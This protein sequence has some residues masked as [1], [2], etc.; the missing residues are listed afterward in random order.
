LAVKGCGTKKHFIYLTFVKSIS[1]DGVQI[2]MIVSGA[3]SRE[4]MGRPYLKT[5]ALF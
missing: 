5:I 1:N 2:K 3:G 4:P